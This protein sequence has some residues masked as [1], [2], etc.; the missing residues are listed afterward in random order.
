MVLTMPYHG[1]AFD[2]S[3]PSFHFFQNR[4]GLVELDAPLTCLPMPQFFPK[5]PKCLL[6]APDGGC[7]TKCFSHHLDE[8][9]RDM[10]AMM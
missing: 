3:C 10:F 7:E 1:L 2:K 9:R 8:Q 6:L 4:T 5:T